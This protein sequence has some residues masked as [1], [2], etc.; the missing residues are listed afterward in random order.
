MF[1]PEKCFS[2]FT[3]V[4]F[5]IFTMFA[6]VS[7]LNAAYEDFYLCSD[8][9]GNEYNSAVTFW[10]DKAGYSDGWYWGYSE[11][12]HEYSR[13]ETLS[14]EWAAAIYYSG[15]YNNTSQWLTD[16]FSYPD[17][18]TYTNFNQDSQYSVWN[19][20]RSARSKVYNSDVN[21]TIDY[22]LID[23]GE[24]NYSPLSFIDANGNS[25]Y[26]KSERY[27]CL[28][29]YTIKNIRADH[30][31]IQDLRFFQF[32]HTHPTGTF[33]PAEFSS[34]STA[35]YPDALKG[36]D[37][38]YPYKNFRFDI[39]QWGTDPYDSE[40]VDWIGFSST[41]EPNHF[42]SGDYVGD[43]YE[44]ETGTHIRIENKSLN[45]EPSISASGAAGAME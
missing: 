11:D 3:F 16:F 6:F 43:Y 25:A 31:T 32:L 45:D 39:T 23:L 22:N 38:V 1:N 13:H 14:G 9:S 27:I 21:V 30:N 19:N 44:P 17:W 40:H 26:V 34:Y 42:D 7:N 33:S 18:Y 8:E 29:T 20:Y 12:K 24:A 37:P 35:N 10:F 15:I 5:I 2:G 28:L 41:V 4:C 36:Y